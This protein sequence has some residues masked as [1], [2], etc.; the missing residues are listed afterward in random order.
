MV[1]AQVRLRC[2]VRRCVYNDVDEFCVEADGD[3]FLVSEEFDTRGVFRAKDLCFASLDE[4]VQCL[5]KDFVVDA[6]QLC[7]FVSA[8]TTSPWSSHIKHDNAP[9]PLVPSPSDSS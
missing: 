6:V 5:E 7:V 1:F 4:N 8:Y 9:D 3:L 2:F